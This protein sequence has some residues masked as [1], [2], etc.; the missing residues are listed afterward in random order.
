MNFDKFH[1]KRNM[2][3]VDFMILYEQKYKYKK[4]EM[5]LPDT[6]EYKIYLPEEVISD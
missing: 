5:V 1:R 2:N 6:R 4:Y 3:M